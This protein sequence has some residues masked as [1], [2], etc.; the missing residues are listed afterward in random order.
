MMVVQSVAMFLPALPFGGAERVAVNLAH[1]F[2]AK[3]LKVTF[4]LQ[5]ATGALLHELPDNVDIVELH[6][7]RT[8]AC[9]L[10]LKRFLEKEKPDILLSHLSHNNIVSIWATRLAHAHTRVVV[11]QHNTLAMESRQHN[12][13][14]YRVLP[15]LYRIFLRFAHG[16]VAVSSGVAQELAHV[17]GLPLQRV[18]MI[19]DGAFQAGFAMTHRSENGASVRRPVY[20]PWLTEHT[21]PLTKRKWRS[22]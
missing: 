16:V 15:L 3:G 10:P 8:L 2:A 18:S 9:V 14:Q 6:Q 20:R 17:S 5:N 11:V 12:G 22:F 1:E 7:K 13:W 4:V 19:G 21:A